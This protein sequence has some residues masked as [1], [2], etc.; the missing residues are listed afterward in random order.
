MD[1]IDDEP[2]MV[3]LVSI[4]M[5]L[6]PHFQTLSSDPNDYNLNPV[7]K[8]F[9]TKENFYREFLIMVFNKGA[10]RPEKCCNTLEIILENNELKS[11]YFNVNDINIIF[12]ITF[13]EMS[14]NQQEQVRVAAF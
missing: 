9:V 13:R 1:F 7:F 6:M 4:L 5:C 11:Y 14:T 10:M 2:T 12:D 3:S 8:E